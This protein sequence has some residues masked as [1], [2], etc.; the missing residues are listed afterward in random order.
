MT[1]DVFLLTFAAWAVS[2]PYNKYTTSQRN[3]HT[4]TWNYAETIET[5]LN[6]T[7]KKIIPHHLTLRYELGQVG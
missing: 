5:T 2:L 4:E 6:S 1:T 3:C 7:T